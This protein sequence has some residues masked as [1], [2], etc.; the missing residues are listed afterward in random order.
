[1]A[2]QYDITGKTPQELGQELANHVAKGEDAIFIDYVKM[3]VDAGAT[4][5]ERDAWGNTPLLSATLHGYP[6]VAAFLIDAGADYNAANK[7]GDTVLHITLRKPG[8]EQSYDD[9]LP[10][11]DIV[12]QKP[13]AN[14]NALNDKKQS[15]LSVAAKEHLY[16]YTQTLVDKGANLDN[17]DAEGKSPLQHA[18]AGSSGAT[19]AQVIETA[20]AERDVRCRLEAQQRAVDDLRQEVSAIVG[21]VGKGSGQQHAAPATARFKARKIESI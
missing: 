8:F 2:L 14:V 10:I 18:Q 21:I 1:M 19:T 7:R 3:L 5:E 20:L 11:A 17:I 12:L 13:D 16:E 4:L 6:D 15:P 9:Y